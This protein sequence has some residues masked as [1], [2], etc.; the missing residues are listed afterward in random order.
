LL[1]KL[2]ERNDFPVP[3][4]MVDLEFDAIWAQHRAAAAVRPAVDSAAAG[5]TG[6]EAA[7]GE[8]APD[9]AGEPAA[10]AAVPDSAG[11]PAADSA[12]P[13]SA[14]EPAA[15]AAVRAEYRKIAERR[16]RLGLLLAEVGRS[17]NIT[18]AQEELNQAVI[19]EARRHVGYERRVLDFYRQHP[20]AVA[21]LRAPIFEDKVIDFITE[22]A[23]LD[24]RRVSPRELLSLPEPDGED[25]AA[26]EPP[27]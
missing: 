24:E 20:E 11:E 15:D 16:V 17:N 10:D 3:P 21:R 25:A 18:V 12:A 13:D 26:A 19:R 14:G 1:D 5:E 6:G 9:S 7:G 4:G 2:A 22:L 23:K 8:A 27:S